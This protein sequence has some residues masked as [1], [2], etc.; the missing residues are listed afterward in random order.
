V[1]RDDP[2]PSP[3]APAR[4][5]AQ[6]GAGERSPETASPARRGAQ[7]GVAERSPEILVV[8]TTSA[9]KLREIQAI[10]GAPGRILRSLADYP[11]VVLPPEGDDY[12]GNALA[13]ARAAA[14]ATGLPAL[15]D[16]SGLEVDALAG[17]PGTHSARFGGPGLDDAGRIALLLRELAG[18]PAEKR[19]ARF[20]CVAAWS[21]PDGLERSA[22]GECPGVLLDAPRGM[23]G[24]G[25]DPIFL[26]EGE[27]RS[28]AELDPERKN[29]ISHRARAF[30]ALV[31][32]GRR[33]SRAPRRPP[34]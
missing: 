25:Y 29:A 31:P 32:D 15:A 14:R 21:S 33:G 4:R 8:A 27:S 7:R 19:R 24:F 28:M 3:A 11:R 17:A 20:V 5:G 10:L 9:G 13:K 34:A 2:P 6:R 22:R 18:V 12:E 16:D 1:K 23:R 30:R 26:P